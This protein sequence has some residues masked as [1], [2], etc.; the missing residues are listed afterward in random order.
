MITAD[1]LNVRR[2]DD[3][4]R[5]AVVALCR[6]ALGWGGGDRDEAFFHWKHDENPAG[7]SPCWIAETAGGEMV[8][9]RIFMRW[10]FEDAAGV[11]LRA[12]R[13]VDT[14]THP[15]WQG[16][17]IFRRLTLGALPDLTD[18]GV[19]FVFNT[20]NDKSRP[21]YL[22]MGWT[23]VGRVP[24]AVRVVG[25]RGLSRMR[26]AR[27]AAE[28]WSVPTDAGVSAADA[29]AD[30]IAVSRL[31]ESI[32]RT[33]AISTRLSPDHLRW[34]YGFAPLHYR[35]LQVGSDL[36]EGCVVFRPRRRGSAT[37]ATVCDLLVPEDSPKAVRVLLRELRRRAGADYLILTDRPGVGRLGFVPAG[38]L[39]PIFTWRPLA[40]DGVPAMDDLT[41]E[42][43]DI[44]LF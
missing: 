31:L 33:S 44:E 16:K 39:G 43:G 23:E 35:V 22:K 5:E 18:E 8:G 2:A 25:L 28:Q 36:A 34:R 41:L 7:A 15:D 24:V 4:D 30:G 6:S 29:F 19:G 42:L 40:R 20:P 13:A 14:A 27:T 1:D 11:T 10:E 9:V 38:S 21:G 32:R 12:V 26:G 37:E 3:T 17:G